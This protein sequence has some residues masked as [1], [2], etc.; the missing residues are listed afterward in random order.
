MLG[1]KNVDVV[2]DKSYC[3][4]N[5]IKCKANNRNDLVSNGYKSRA[6][7]GNV[8]TNGG[9]YLYLAFAES[10]FKTANAR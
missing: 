7:S 4:K 2:L 8:N 10:P 6:T 9:T 3:K 5:V 1:G